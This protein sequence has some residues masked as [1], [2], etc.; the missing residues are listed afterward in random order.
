M[1]DGVGGGRSLSTLFTLSGKKNDL[2]PVNLKMICSVKDLIKRWKLSSFK[3][4]MMI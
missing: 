4:L 3:L 1:R 2:M